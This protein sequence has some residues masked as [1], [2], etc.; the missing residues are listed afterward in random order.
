LQMADLCEADLG[1]C[2]YRSKDSIKNIRIKVHI[3][4][5]TSASIVPQVAIEQESGDNTEIK[6]RRLKENTTGGAD[7]TDTYTFKWQ[8]KVFSDREIQLYNDA[9]KCESVLERT[10]HE[11]VVK[12]LHDG[13]P[14]KR[15]FSYVDHDSF[16]NKDETLKPM[17]TSPTETQTTLAEKMVNVRRRKTGGLRLRESENAIVPKINIVNQKPSDDD[18]KHNHIINTPVQTMFI[19]ADLSMKEKEAVEA[20][21]VVLCTLKYDNHSVLSIKPDFTKTKKPYRIETGALGRDLYEYTIEHSSY[22]MNRQEQNREGKMYR[23]LYN[24]HAEFLHALVGV[25]FEMPPPEV[26]RLLVFGEIE[27][28]KHFEY[29]DLYIHYFIELPKNWSV[30]PHQQLSGVTQRC[31]TKREGRDSVAYFSFPFDF[32][33]FYKNDVINEANTDLL[34]QWPMLYLEVL[35]LDSWQRYRTEGYGYVKL[36]TIP[37]TTTATVNCW[38]PLGD[39]RSGELRRFF[40]GG[41]P[42]L[43]DPTYSGIPTSF[44]GNILSKFGFTTATTGEVSVRFNSIQQS[45][46]FL[47]SATSK[48]KMGRLIDRLG[49]STAQAGIMNVLEAFQRARQRMI[50]AR[51]NLTKDFK[52][53]TI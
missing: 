35:S 8:E 25:D 6:E 1:T 53:M 49:T 46:S 43:E 12:V 34:P 41:S 10:Y 33:L 9:N 5:V 4:K 20:D 30:D 38:R 47:D 23:E 15:L 31:S 26:L 24:R 44:E 48:K 18:K 42:E 40:I 14:T 13:K 22:E 45:Q 36:P 28:A 11:Q 37:G 29:D 3:K 17:T 2:F 52:D 27:S 51:D 32:Q 16:T 19:M 21:E 39:T 7:D 50:A